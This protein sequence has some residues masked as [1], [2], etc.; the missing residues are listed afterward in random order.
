MPKIEAA[1]SDLLSLAGLKGAEKLSE[2]LETMKAELDGIQDD[3]VK[4]ELNDTNRPDLW[5]VEGV[6]RGIRCWNNGAEKHLEGMPEP[7]R[8]LVVHKGLEA[9]RPFIASFVSRNLALGDAGLSAL[10]N[11]Q[12]KLCATMGRDRRTAATGF[13]RLE[14]IRFPV[15]YRA[16]SPDTPFHPLGAAG[17]MPLRA[18]LTETETG[19][20]Y[21]GLLRGFETY[22]FLEDDRGQPLSFP[23]VLNS[24]GTGRVAPEDADLFCEVTGTDLNT[25]QLLATIL[26]CAL[27]DRGASIEPVRVIYPDG[28]SVVTPV[29]HADTL[30]VNLELVRAATGLDIPDDRI[31]PLLSKMDYASVVVEN[32]VVKAVMPPYR[33]DGIHPMDLVE[34]ITIA[35]GLNLIEPLLPPDYTL[36]R[37]SRASQLSSA[38]KLLLVGAGCEEIIRPVLTSSQKV[39]ELTRTPEPPVA[40]TNPMTAEYS[41]VS[42]TVLPCL[43]EVES[44]SGHASFPHRLFTVGEVLRRRKD[45]LLDTRWSLGLLTAGAGMDF[46]SA[47]SL[48]GVLAHG[49]GLEL[50]LSP[51]DDPRFI[52][53]RSA[54]VTLSGVEAGVIGEFHP[55]VLDAWGI[56]VPVS[57]FE[58]LLEALGG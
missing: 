17:R 25:V 26:A 32:G 50:K 39:T 2:L 42:N 5:T 10:V 51:A 22:P 27:E 53:G 54:I 38:V 23:P 11:S 45:S 20:K 29:I 36:G 24:E 21:S 7:C 18:V 47:H 49:R 43:F 19:V 13:Y 33:R 55:E 35:Y 1:L 28:A 44:V 46:G 34:D 8:E 56:Q 15:H 40:I 30:S 9:N 52:P 6:A 16:V 14:G 31:P 4:I 37:P 57:G 3:T 12:E 41:A 58:V 48:L